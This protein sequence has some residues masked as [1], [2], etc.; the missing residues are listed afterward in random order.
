LGKRGPFGAK[1]KKA[2]VERALGKNKLVDHEP[3]GKKS[4]REKKK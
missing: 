4:E 1:W 2:K 3:P